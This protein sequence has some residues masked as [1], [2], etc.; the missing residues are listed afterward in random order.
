MSP[1]AL[2]VLEQSESLQHQYCLAQRFGQGVGEG[3]VDRM[4]GPHLDTVS[5]LHL[6]SHTHLVTGNIHL[7]ERSPGKSHRNRMALYT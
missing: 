2:F 7:G 5:V 4:L 6:G 1:G 3:D